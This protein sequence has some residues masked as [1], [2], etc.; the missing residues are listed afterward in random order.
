[1]VSFDGCPAFIPSQWAECISAVG[2]SEANIHQY[3]DSLEG[4]PA[5][6]GWT[7]FIFL[8]QNRQSIFSS[9]IPNPHC[10]SLLWKADVPLKHFALK[11]A[12]SQ[13]FQLVLPFFFFCSQWNCSQF[14]LLICLLLCALP[15]DSGVNIL[16]FH[17]SFLPMLN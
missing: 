14:P 17:D 9:G 15:L 11:Q 3:H 4:A 7:I 10:T 12:S 6:D 2:I 13:T 16:G 5:W 1:M 8:P